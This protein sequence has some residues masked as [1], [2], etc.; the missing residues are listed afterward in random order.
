[1]KTAFVVCGALAREVLEIVGRRSW[2]VKVVAVSALDHMFP[3]RIA[4]DVERQLL[5]L[6][7]RYERII[8]VY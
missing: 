4:P 1:V 6:R 7:A 3:E 8:V 2:D 5:A